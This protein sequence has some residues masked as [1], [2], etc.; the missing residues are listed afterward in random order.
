[1]SR[2]RS[3]PIATNLFCDLEDINSPLWVSVFLFMRKKDNTISAMSV[4]C[5]CFGE[6]FVGTLQL[7]WW[8]WG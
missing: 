1:M 2:S 8:R 4:R 5:S 3:R 6:P 7:V